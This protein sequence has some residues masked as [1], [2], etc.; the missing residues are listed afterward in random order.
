MEIFWFLHLCSAFH[1]KY[2][3]SYFQMWHGVDLTECTHK[4]VYVQFYI[5]P[6]LQ[7]RKLRWWEIRYVRQ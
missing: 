6:V 2:Y 4:V 1:W 5:G 3:P 7:M